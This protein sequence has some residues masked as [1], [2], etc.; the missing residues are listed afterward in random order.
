MSYLKTLE[1][2]GEKMEVS[3]PPILTIETNDP[4]KFQ[5]QCQQMVEADYKMVSS[6]CGFLN[7]E[8]HDFQSWFQAIFQD[9]SIGW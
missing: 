9:R 1:K 2:D 8:K 6:N 3:R 5:E 7:S 4:T